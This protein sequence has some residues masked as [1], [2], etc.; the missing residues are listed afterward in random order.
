MPQRAVQ[1]QVL[2]SSGRAV[3]ALLVHPG[4]LRSLS[5]GCELTSALRPLLRGLTGLE[6]LMLPVMKVA[7]GNH[8]PGGPL[9]CLATL[10]R[11]TGARARSSLS[12]TTCPAK[13]LWS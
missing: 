9:R 3:A 7:A 11:L 5:L 10:T 12:S 13:T 6:Q 4:Q 1:V 2:R 8:G